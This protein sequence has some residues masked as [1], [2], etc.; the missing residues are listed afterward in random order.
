MRDLFGVV[1]S[2]L[3]PW[4]VGFLWVGALQRRASERNWLL[5]AGYGYPIGALATTLLL[6]AVSVLTQPWSLALVALPLV[7]LAIGGYWLARPAAAWSAAWTH[8]RDADRSAPVALRTVFWIAIS[9]ITIRLAGLAAEVCLRPLL[10]W[11]AWSQW[12]TKAVVW[13][14]YGWMA[15]FVSATQWLAADDPL[16]FVDMH[17]NYPATVPL[18]QVWTALCIGHW[19]ES[20]VNAPWPALACALALAFYG[21]VR[22]LGTG[23]ATAAVC[24]Y[25]LLSLPFLDLHVALAGCAD[26]FMAV[27]YGLAAMAL[28]Q[29]TLTRQRND[30]VLALIMAVACIG[31][32]TE[33][34]FWALTL[35]P[36]ILV[37]VKR[38]VGFWAIGVLGCSALFYLL[39]GPAE[40]VIFGYKLRTAFTNV[41]QPVLEHLFLMDNWHLLW[42]ATVAMLAANYRYLLSAEMA[43]M[44]VTM[45]GAFAFVFVV[46]FFSSAG[47]GVDD[48]SLVNRLLLHLVPALAFYLVLLWRK[49]PR[50]AALAAGATSPP[51]PSMT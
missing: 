40:L 47:G 9:L 6:R 16:H 13:Y 22:R 29:W 10:P 49:R 38:R 36:A 23:P 45:L 34:I 20:L 27:A 18:L 30:A 19:D 7:L 5:S 48:E 17:S 39:F 50:R 42:Y 4:V 43:P 15:P 12:A 37:A 24:T 8:G 14:H 2:V 3:L 32:K 31:L 41:S 44:S 46:F 25:L 21:H 35:V 51:A 33:G 11:D 28:W 1:L 26:L